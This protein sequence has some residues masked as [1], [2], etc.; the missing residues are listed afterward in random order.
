MASVTRSTRRAEGLHPHHAN[1]HI[2]RSAP[3][4]LF[5]HHQGATGGGAGHKRPFDAATV[6]D[7]EFDA[8]KPKRARIAVEI[9][10]RG[11]AIAPDNVKLPPVVANAPAPPRSKPTVATT[12]SAA[13]PAPATT[14]TAPKTTSIAET[15]QN[16]TKH[17]AKVINGIKHELDRLQ[18]QATDTKE[19]GRKLRSQEASRFKSELSAYF[20]DYDEVIGNEPR[21]QRTCQKKNTHRSVPTYL[22]FFMI[23]DQF[24]RYV[25]RRHADSN[26]RL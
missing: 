13:K 10:A 7:R 23:A 17:Q 25:E 5:H 18:P 8:I 2:T 6:S 9:L 1:S 14:A 19:H 22:L 21:E 24:S 3:S 16:L 15:D 12:T 4:A 11:S 20:P 26:R